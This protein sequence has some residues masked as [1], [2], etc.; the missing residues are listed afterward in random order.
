MNDKGVILRRVSQKD[1]FGQLLHQHFSNKNPY[2]LDRGQYVIVIPG[3]TFETIENYKG[4]EKMYGAVKGTEIWK[5]IRQYGMVVVKRS[6]KI[7]L[8]KKERL[9]KETTV[10]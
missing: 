8:W 4:I 2:L 3:K 5:K 6:G 10:E 7:E 9:E 1:N